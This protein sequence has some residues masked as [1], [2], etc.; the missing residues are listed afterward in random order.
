MK[1]WYDVRE[2]PDI[3][4]IG[5]GIMSATIAMMLKELEPNLTIAVY[6]RL[7]EA[8]RE[9]SDA[10]NNAGTGHSAFCELNYTPADKKG[11]VDIKKAIKIASQ[12]ETSK[13]FWAHLIE[14][15]YLENP[16][17]FIRKV[18]H[19][20]IVWEDENVAFLKR[21]HAAMAKHAL[22][23]GMKLTTKPQEIFKWIPLVMEKRD[24]K[25]SVAAT[26]IDYG[27]DVNYGNL[28]R[29]LFKYLD[30]RAGITVYYN[31]EVRD[32]TRDKNGQW[33]LTVVDL[34]KKKKFHVDTNFVFVGAGGGALPLLEKSGI[35]EAKG[36]GGFPVSGQWLRC[37]NRTVIEKHSAK[38]YGKASVGTPPMSVPHLDTRYID[39]KKELLFGPYAG[40]S[41]KFLKKGSYLDLMK[42]LEFTNLIPMIAAGLHNVSLTKYLIQQA[43]QSHDERMDALREF[44]PDAKNADWELLVAGQRVQVIRSDEEK[45]GVLEFGTE[46][47]AA[48]DSSL[49]ALLGASPGASTSVSIAL[50][51]LGR[52][53]E[54]NMQS[55]AWKKKL[56]EMV[57]SYGKS[58]ANN[59]KLIA[60]MRRRSAKVLQLK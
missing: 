38:V 13:Q 49:V 19:L 36:Y 16:Q 45:G 32:L 27:T 24:P 56:R 21:R 25:Q 29:S 60:A 52:C 6:E 3:V 41:T 59:S 44:M 26:R 34:K 18:P 43:T 7:P 15:G 39:G 1:E 58:L 10:W 50:D 35:P 54:S 53:F 42:S 22:F 20:S 46:I 9:S 14:K 2:T 57:P 4:L 48:H 28:T 33:N 47:I 55:K 51:V 11:R 17:N 23:S 31:H 40:F 8:A 37:K 5:A 30:Q 12:F